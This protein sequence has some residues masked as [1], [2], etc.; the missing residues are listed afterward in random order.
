M[1]KEVVITSNTPILRPQNRMAAFLSR[2]FNLEGGQLVV[3]GG[4]RDP[5]VGGGQPPVLLLYDLSLLT[6]TFESVFFR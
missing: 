5:P 4:G 3:G 6:L 1:I 2:I